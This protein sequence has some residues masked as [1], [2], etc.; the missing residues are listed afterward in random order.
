MPRW[1][2]LASAKQP[3]CNTSNTKQPALRDL[4]QVFAGDLRGLWRSTNFA[5]NQLLGYMGG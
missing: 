2:R 3:S 5:A 1:V 4:D